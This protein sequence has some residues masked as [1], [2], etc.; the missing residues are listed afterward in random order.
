[1][2]LIVVVIAAAGVQRTGAVTASRV[3]RRAA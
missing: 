2:V 3:R 1:V